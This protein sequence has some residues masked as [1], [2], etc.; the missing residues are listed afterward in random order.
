M[1]MLFGF[2]HFSIRFFL[3]GFFLHFISLLL[4]LSPFYLFYLSPSEVLIDYETTS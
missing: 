4:F 1:K 2:T 3:L